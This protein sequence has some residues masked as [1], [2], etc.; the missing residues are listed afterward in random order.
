MSPPGTHLCTCSNNWVAERLCTSWGSQLLN[1]FLWYPD[2]MTY[3][4]I[5]S[6]VR[7]CSSIRIYVWAYATVCVIRCVRTHFTN[8]GMCQNVDNVVVS[9]V[10]ARFARPKTVCFVSSGR[11]PLPLQLTMG[12]AG[13]VLTHSPVAK[14]LWCFQKRWWCFL[15][16]SPSFLKSP[17]CF[18][19]R[20]DGTTL[21]KSVIPSF[22]F[23][24]TFYPK[25]ADN[26]SV[27]NDRTSPHPPFIR[28]SRVLSQA[29]FSNSLVYF[30]HL[31]LDYRKWKRYRNSS[32]AGRSF[33]DERRLKGGW[34][35]VLSQP[36]PP[37]AGRFSSRWKEEGRNRFPLVGRKNAVIF[38]DSVIARQAISGISRLLLIF[39]PLLRW[40]QRNSRQQ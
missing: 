3:I 20:E 35:D 33:T 13:L 19:V 5:G 21:T 14:R 6:C 1:T 37:S 28:A 31:F 4:R 17:V 23:I 22:P 9:L 36:K 30:L 10:G 39:L 40:I 11:Q 7:T 26:Q 25:H 12:W 18:Y 2:T 32:K 38:M 34:N 29:A 15:K 8:R 16:T 24:L 27:K